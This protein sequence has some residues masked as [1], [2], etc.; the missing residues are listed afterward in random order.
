MVESKVA[1]RGWRLS[2]CSH[3]WSVLKRRRCIPLTHIQ[4][5]LRRSESARDKQALAQSRQ[6]IW[7]HVHRGPWAPLAPCRLRHLR[8]DRSCRTPA[9]VLSLSCAHLTLPPRST[10]LRNMPPYVD[11]GMRWLARAFDDTDTP[12]DDNPTLPPGSPPTR[13]YTSHTLAPIHSSTFYHSQ[14][15]RPLVCHTDHSFY[16]HRPR[17]LSRLLVLPHSVA[18]PL[19]ATNKAQRFVFAFS[20]VCL[21]H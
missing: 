9:N 12:G 1:E 3:R 19:R 21:K 20:S 11:L 17:I 18:N 2:S 5:G 4:R 8:D 14:I 15:R 13:A 6:S 7:G 10:Q 16:N